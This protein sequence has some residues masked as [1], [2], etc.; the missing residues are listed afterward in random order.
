MVQGKKQS[1]SKPK[2]AEVVIGD[3]EAK[4][5]REE[6]FISAS[7]SFEPILV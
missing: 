7:S 6:F 5:M 4:E 3:D 1:T 2:F